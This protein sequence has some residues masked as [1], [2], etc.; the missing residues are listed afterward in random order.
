MSL[1]ADEA[2]RRHTKL[3]VSFALDPRL[4][5]LAVAFLDELGFEAFSSDGSTMNAYSDPSIWSGA[6]RDAL[7]AW[8]GTHD[9]TGL[10]T[11]RTIQPQNWNAEWESSV[12]PVR[13]A[14]FTI[15]PT[16]ASRGADP[17]DTV[18]LIDPKMSFGTGHHASTRLALGLLSE[19]ITPGDRVLDAG[20]GSGVLSIAAAK[21]GAGSVVA[22]DYDEWAYRNA[23]ENF[24]LNGVSSL[25]DNRLGGLDCVEG[26]ERFDVVLANIHREVIL[27]MLDRFAALIG[28]G[29]RLIVSGLLLSDRG[30]IVAAADAR[31]LRLASERAEDEW[32]GACFRVEH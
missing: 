31:G 5:D 2:L 29:G 18:I 30:D 25:I 19:G 9:S 28:D 21:S 13:V 8:L 17:A 24:E 1:P 27:S 11:E 4:H 32:F 14:G 16:W 7:H 23:E 10:L 26:S 20:A 15:A 6:V 22:F 12:R 3:E